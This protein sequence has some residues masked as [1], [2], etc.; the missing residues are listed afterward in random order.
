MKLP[1]I[2]GE[3][4]IRALKK[5]GFELVGVRGSNHYLHH[6]N[7]G[8]L[9]TVPVHSGKI[10]APKTIQTILLQAGITKE[11]FRELL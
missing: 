7:T 9:V 1:R 6:P 3:K 10:L 2:P 11:D 4:V 5:A 8:T